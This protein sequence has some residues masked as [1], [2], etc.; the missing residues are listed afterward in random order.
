MGFINLVLYMR[1]LRHGAHKRVAQG[2]TTSKWQ[3]EKGNL[4]LSDFEILFFF[5]LSYT[6]TVRA[7]E[8]GGRKGAL[9][10][11]VALMHG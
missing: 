2:H 4:H 3:M 6:A 8:V 5:L 9:S 11:A 1:K 7:V 10:A